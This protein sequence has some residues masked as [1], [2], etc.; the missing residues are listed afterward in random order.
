VALLS[1]PVPADLSE[2]H[3]NNASHGAVIAPA[4]S[5]GSAPCPP[6]GNSEWVAVA[7][8]DECGIVCY[9]VDARELRTRARFL[10]QGSTRVSLRLLSHHLCLADDQGRL[11]ALDLDTGVLIRDLRI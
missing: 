3:V 2:P 10:L 11:L 6:T 8:K 4:T 9:V 5:P 1:P 7:I